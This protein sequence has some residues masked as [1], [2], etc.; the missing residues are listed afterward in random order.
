[1]L[2][3]EFPANQCNPSA[4]G[5][6]QQFGHGFDRQDDSSRRRLIPQ[7]RWLI[8]VQSAHQLRTDDFHLT[9]VL[10]QDARIGREGLEGLAAL[11]FS[12]GALTGSPL[13][14]EVIS[15]FHQACAARGRKTLL[16]L[17]QFLNEGIQQLIAVVKEQ[18]QA[19]AFRS[20]L[21]RF[22]PEA[23]PLQTG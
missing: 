7:C 10:D 15:P 5:H 9:V 23:F 21:L 2:P 17:T 16:E 18:L 13:R 12:I 19:L 11:Q 14:Q 20:Q 3:C 22:L 8:E 4:G 1:M 6:S